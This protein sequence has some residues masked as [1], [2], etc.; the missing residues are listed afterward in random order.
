MRIKLDRENNISPDE[1]ILANYEKY[2]KKIDDI[3]NDIFAGE[4]KEVISPCSNIEDEEKRLEKLLILLEGR[5]SKRQNL[6]DRYYAATGEYPVFFQPIVSSYELNEKRERLNLINKYLDTKNE[7]SNV[8]DDIT[9]MKEELSHEEEKKDSYLLKNKLME[10]ELYSLFIGAIKN[11]PFYNDLDEEEL[12]DKLKEVASKASEMK[13]TFDVTLDSIKNLAQN[14]IEDDYGTYIDDAAKSYY[15]WKNRELVL[16]IYREVVILDDDFEKMT[17]KREK[18][19]AL[20][21][22]R[23]NL[24]NELSINELDEFFDFDKALEEQLDV[25]KEERDILENINTFNS[26]IKYKEDRLSE[27][28][29]NNKSAEILSILREYNLVDTYDDTDD[30]LLEEEL[31][32]SDYHFDIPSQDD[33]ADT[34]DDELKIEFIDPYR[35]A[36]V[37]DYP[38]TLNIGLAKLKGESVR[39]KVNK[40]LN[41]QSAKQLFED[42]LS[43][44]SSEASNAE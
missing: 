19:S 36:E 24:K 22:E 4:I 26:R 8:T 37:K 40:K 9:K 16:K 15:E 32:A 27:L 28:K 17:A 3:Y 33:L 14:G 10:D 20:V 25:L 18:I 44:E 7:I 1:Q 12:G 31:K 11:D 13:E 30:E 35:I 21:E 43:K 2:A 5:L 41:P 6:E 38:K 29:E 34:D 23:T 39:E 42:Y